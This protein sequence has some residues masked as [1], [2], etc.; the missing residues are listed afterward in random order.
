ML[1]SLLSCLLFIRLKKRKLSLVHS[2]IRLAL[3]NH[4]SL[5]LYLLMASVNG[6]NHQCKTPK[7]RNSP[8]PVLFPNFSLYKRHCFAAKNRD[9][10]LSYRVLFFPNSKLQTPN[11][12]LQTPNSKLPTPTGRTSRLRHKPK[13]PKRAAPTFVA[14]NSRTRTLQ[15]PRCARHR[16]AP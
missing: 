12:K 8:E 11:S 1:R 2:G 14:S 3:C 15:K 7:H 10:H 16:S 4:C 13:R 6:L 9:P 5:L